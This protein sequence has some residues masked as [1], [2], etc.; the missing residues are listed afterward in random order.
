MAE[1]S[2]YTFTFYTIEDFYKF[3]KDNKKE[4]FVRQLTSILN[5]KF[6]RFQT[7]G[8]YH[9]SFIIKTVEGIYL[10]LDFVAPFEEYKPRWLR[11]F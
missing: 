11:L 3:I 8:L 6:Y 10:K 9:V 4:K 7:S 1:S 2:T 5:G